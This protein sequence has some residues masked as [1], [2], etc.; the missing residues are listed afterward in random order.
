[1]SKKTQTWITFSLIII[2]CILLMCAIIIPSQNYIDELYEAGF[3]KPATCLTL[4]SVLFA[5]TIAG[6][7][8][9]LM[10]FSYVIIHSDDDKG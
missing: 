5:C 1:M 10:L 2:V 7:G 6:I 4:I 9:G 8:S 3:N